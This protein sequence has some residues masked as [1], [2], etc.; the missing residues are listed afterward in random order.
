MILG[1]SLKIAVLVVVPTPFVRVTGP[2]TAPGG[3]MTLS[4]VAVGGTSGGTGPAPLNVTAVTPSRF[5]PVIVSVVPTG[6]GFGL[7]PVARGGCCTVRF[8]RLAPSRPPS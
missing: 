7:K 1:S 2:V 5:V 8:V 4:D 6:A 3:T